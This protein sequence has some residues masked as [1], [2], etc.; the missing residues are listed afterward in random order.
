MVASLTCLLACFAMI[1]TVFV[2]GRDGSGG[3]DDDDDDDDVCGV[4]ML[5][6]LPSNENDTVSVFIKRHLGH[7]SD[8]S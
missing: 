6:V 4:R 1:I 2:G 5:P 7:W 8:F 3:S